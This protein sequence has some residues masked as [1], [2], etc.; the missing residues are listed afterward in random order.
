MQSLPIK[1]LPLNEEMDSNA[2]ATIQGG[3][4]KIPGSSVHNQVVLPKSSIDSYGPFND[5][6]LPND[7]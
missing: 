2:M 5:F 4:M 7:D 1:D 3:R 6:I